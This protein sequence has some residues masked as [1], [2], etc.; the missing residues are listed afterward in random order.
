[1]RRFELQPVVE[2]AAE[3]TR[4]AAEA[5]SVSLAIHVER[6][7]ELSGD[8]DRI[9]QVVWNLLSNAVKF[10]DSGGHVRLDAVRAGHAVTI[11]VA[12]DGIGIA[13]GFLPYVFERFRQ[14]DPSSTRV[15][16]GLGLG[17]AITRHLVELH[18]G[19]IRAASAGRGRGATFTVTLPAQAL[20]STPVVEPV[21]GRESANS[22]ATLAP[23]LEGVRLLV[24]DDEMEA[25]ELLRVLLQTHGAHVTTAASAPQ[26]LESIRRG[27]FDVVLVD[28]AM[29]EEDGYS[30]IRRLRAFEDGDGSPPP[31]IA[32]T[33]YARDE[34]R[35]R[36]AA[37][38][39]QLHLAKP[40]DPDALL[41]A[42]QRVAKRPE[43]LTR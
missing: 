3:T 5:R 27:A 32:L 4:L 19:S 24:V 33:A 29:P 40:V 25:R 9:Q 17:L 12:D 16:G 38:G 13:A 35:R 2:A 21:R 42:V 34:D 26:A 22:A 18:G 23:A 6:G 7:I 37:S 36:A 30:L 14:A 31:A 39:F 20:R 43:R 41:E 10:T 1:V 11:E 28:I 15:H 8:P